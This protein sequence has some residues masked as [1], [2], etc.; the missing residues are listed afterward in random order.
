MTY[1]VVVSLKNI[2]I[3]VKS[4]ENNNKNKIKNMNISMSM[5][6]STSKIKR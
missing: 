2:A 3:V 5:S 1:T 6:M 4:I